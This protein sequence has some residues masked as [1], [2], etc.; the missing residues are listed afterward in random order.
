M[1]F[2]PN[3]DEQLENLKSHFEVI[4]DQIF[5]IEFNMDNSKLSEYISDI[6]KMNDTSVWKMKS[7]DTLTMTLQKTVSW[8]STYIMYMNYS[9][10]L[11]V[12]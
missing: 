1:K 11:H 10:K 6:S 5:P 3:E 4:N 9:L 12:L 7:L 2:E 8:Y